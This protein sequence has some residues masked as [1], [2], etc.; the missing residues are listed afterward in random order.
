MKD[1]F[2]KFGGE[3][4]PDVGQYIRDY[5][6]VYPRTSVYVGTDSVAKRGKVSYATV[7]A[8]YDEERKDGV[9]YIFKRD[10][11]IGKLDVFSRMWREVEKSLEVA[12]YL[13][14]ELDGHLRRYSVED[15][16]VMKNPAGGY[17]KVNQNK[18][19]TID[20]DI[21]PTSGGGKNKSYIAYE[22]AKGTVVGYGYRER[23]KPH[24]WAA[25][26]CADLV[27]K[28]MGARKERKSRKKARAAA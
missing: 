3:Q 13:E 2:K 1:K 21:S 9:H 7:I 18:L 11:E 6:K 25:N 12:E 28:G 14:T 17:Y 27:A 26:C 20:I 22:A 5:L 19:V 16:M 10:K 8:F 24:C 15:L 23:F 4:I